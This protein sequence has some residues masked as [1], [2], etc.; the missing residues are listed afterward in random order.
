MQ[1]HNTINQIMNANYGVMIQNPFYSWFPIT[2]GILDEQIKHF[3]LLLKYM[4][5]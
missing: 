4:Y 1:I 2:I 3:F 5:F